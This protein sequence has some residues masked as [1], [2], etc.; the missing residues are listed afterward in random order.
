RE[1]ALQEIAALARQ[2]RLSLQE[3]AALLH[4]PGDKPKQ[5]GE[6]VTKLFSYLGGIFCLA[7]ICA[8]IGMFWDEMSGAVRVTLTFGTGLVAFLM[9]VIFVRDGRYARIVT[10]LFLIAA[11]F[12]PGGLFVV[13]DEY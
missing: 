5:A 6:A 11:L 12:Q 7:G 13:F 1:E 4:H 8:Y 2:H 9:A 3:I 10:P